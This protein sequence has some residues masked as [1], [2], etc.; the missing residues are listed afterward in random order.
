MILLLL[1]KKKSNNWSSI[2]MFLTLTATCSLA[3]RLEG[4][5]A[6]KFFPSTSTAMVNTGTWTGPV[7]E[8]SLYCR[9]GFSWFRR[10]RAFM[11]CGGSAFSSG[12]ER[13]KTSW[14][15]AMCANLHYKWIM[16]IWRTFTFLLQFLLLLV[17]ILLISRL[18]LLHGAFHWRNIGCA[19]WDLN[20]ADKTR[21][22]GSQVSPAKRMD[23]LLHKN[24][25]SSND[26]YPQPLHLTCVVNRSLTP[27]LSG[28]FWRK[29]IHTEHFVQLSKSWKP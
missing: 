4:P 25:P 23:A 29:R 13:Q 21:K 22:K 27:R 6:S 20:Y 26:E 5:E 14:F 3:V 1:W 8:M 10:I 11:A 12:A 24:H 15:C 17:W 9:P 28:H 2:S 7:W 18:L 16:N 19:G